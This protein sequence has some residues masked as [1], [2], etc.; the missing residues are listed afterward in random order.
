[1][2]TV[3]PVAIV[4]ILV[5]AEALA[6]T[7]FNPA[8]SDH[9]FEV[10]VDAGV[11]CLVVS[12]EVVAAVPGRCVMPEVVIRANSMP[13]VAVGAARCLSLRASPG[14]VLRQ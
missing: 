6:L 1:M 8:V 7:W 13:E 3:F 10:R 4:V 11:R 9:Q 14:R 5:A 12:S 2:K